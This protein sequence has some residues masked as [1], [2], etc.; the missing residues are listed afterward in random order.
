MGGTE[1]NVGKP[2]STFEIPRSLDL[3]NYVYFYLAQNLDCTR[4]IRFK[5]I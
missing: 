3:T 4:D 2:E 1:G 5:L